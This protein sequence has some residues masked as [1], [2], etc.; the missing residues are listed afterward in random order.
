[1]RVLKFGGTS[2]ANAEKFQ[3]VLQIII[4]KFKKEQIGIVLSAP[5]TITNL[6][7]NSIT[8]VL[9]K[10]KKIKE[11]IKKIYI[12][13]RNLINSFKTTKQIIKYKKLKKKIKKKCIFLQKKLKIIKY[14]KT[15]SDSIKA[16]I[17][18]IGE[19][20]SVYIM[21]FLLKI[22]KY[23]IT[24]IDPVKNFIT[25]GT[26]LNSKIDLKNSKNN[27]EKL[28]IPKTNIILMPGFIAGNQNKKLVI[29][30]RNGSDYSAAALSVCTNAKICEIWTDVDGIYT[31][32]PQKISTAVLLKNLIYQEAQELSFFG[33]KILHPST[34][35]PLKKNNIPCII[36]NTNNLTSKGT[37]INNE[38]KKSH[39][40]IKGL[41]YIKK[42]FLITFKIFKKIKILKYIE[43]IL[44]FI[45]IH[46]IKI[47]FIKP[48]YTH[49]K[50]LI[51]LP[52]EKKKIILKNLN[53]FFLK[54]LS[55]KKIIYFKITQNLSLISLISS[56]FYYNHYIIQFIFQTIQKYKK[57]IIEIDHSLYN[58]HFLILLN[59]TILSSFLKTL[60][61]KIYYQRKKIHIFIIGIGGIGQTLLKQITQQKEF[62][63]NKNKKI[64]IHVISNSKKYLF[65]KKNI[66]N[67]DLKNLKQDTLKNFDLKE[68]LK[69]PENFNIQ[70]PIL[71]DCTSS[72]QIAKN[73]INIFKKGFHIVS[74]NKKSNTT[75]FQS[76][77]KIH[78]TA[79]FY[80]KKFFYET[81]VGAGLPIIKNLKNL[82]STG[83]KFQKFSGILSGSMSFIFG[84][85]EKNITFSKAVKKAKKLGFT[86]PDPR[87]D[88]SGID[89]ARKLL[90][91]AREIGYKLEL[92]DIKIENILPKNIL[93]LKNIEEVMTNLTTL[94]NIFFEKNKI[95]QKMNQVLRFIGTI[96]K[97]G[98]CEVKLKSISK[99]NPL[100]KIKNGENIFVFYTQYYSPIPLIIQGY[101]AGK[102]VTA[103]G[104]FSDLLHI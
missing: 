78:K 29:L 68:I 3:I 82:L 81:H 53:N 27:I 72:T 5:S 92:S 37:K 64:C 20:I 11:I 41:T 89:I 98:V 86:E 58:F 7:F 79:L 22:K 12:F 62:L 91:I 54:D 60:H 8:L 102:N 57:N 71:I 19:K 43:L 66:L 67:F 87:E 56:N 16:K 14:A 25:T 48:S 99:K 46:K 100:Y 26:Y 65:D 18:S 36:K 28:K 47:F 59:N 39:V 85:L 42:I 52:T 44:N 83:D 45:N 75:N 63:K 9:E 1:M 35:S 15:C 49:Q 24:I 40:F 90:I 94:D 21:Y 73:Y 69:L 95:A 30:G 6:L 74:A 55:K 84:L 17:I 97:D 4:K 93:K 70:N 38:T 50:I 23:H 80:K 32:D 33:A 76:Y 31:C 104:M 61:Q 2:L 13:F 10:K 51:C 103:S 77:K 88:L 34:I 96:K 101:G